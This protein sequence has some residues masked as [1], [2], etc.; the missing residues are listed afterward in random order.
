MKLTSTRRSAIKKHD[1]ANRFCRLFFVVLTLLH[2]QPFVAQSGMT[3]SI[4]GTI[5]DLSGAVLP[6]AVIT[7]R[8]LNTGG[9]RQVTSS[10]NGS[11]RITPLDPGRYTLRVELAT[12]RT[13]EQPDIVLSIGQVA[14][15][16]ASLTIGATNEVITVT[17]GA[18]VIQT[19]DSSIG[20]VVDAPTIV[21]T[22]LNGR[23]G[24]IGLIALAPGVQNAGAQ[25]QIPVF[26]VTPSIGSGARNAYGAVASSMDGAINMWVAL[27]R[28]LGATPP[29]DG[30]AEFKVITSAAPAEF[31][32]ASQITVATKGGANDNG[33]AIRKFFSGRHRRHH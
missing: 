20:A 17:G 2:T 29:L 25:D 21:N 16:N 32:Q 30:I 31:G 4:T 9:V 15:I 14:E 11:Y 22:P 10:D 26:G 3:A 24:V 12:F 7:A 1:H 19:E 28:P 33:H 8:N 27:Q 5:T 23:L 6:Q 18:P 13:F